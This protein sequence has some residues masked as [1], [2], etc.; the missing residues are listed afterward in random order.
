MHA[1]YC[2]FA[3]ADLSSVTHKHTATLNWSPNLQSQKTYSYLAV[4]YKIYEHEMFERR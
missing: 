1:Y 2:T 3:F 4:K